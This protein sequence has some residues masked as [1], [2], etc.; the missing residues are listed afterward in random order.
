MLQ[1]ALNI[2]VREDLVDTLGGEITIALDGPVLPTPSWKV[3]AEV[4]DPARLQE[5]LR[6][7]VAFAGTQMKTDQKI[8]I[9]QQTEDGITYYTFTA[10]HSAK[11]LEINYAFNDGYLIVGPSRPLVK[12]AVQIHKG[13]NS[14]AKSANF[15]KLLPQD[16][17]TNVSALLYQNISPVLSPLAQTLSPSQL[18]IFQQLAAES[19]PS[20]VCAYGEDNAIRV[21]SNTRFLDMNTLAL[22]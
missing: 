21:A 5:T 16:R 1:A 17:N 13:G 19:K 11:G 3:I 8:N 7:L 4:N 12:A 18:Q 10:P 9:D 2:R 6:K 22:T 14:L 15:H 20:V